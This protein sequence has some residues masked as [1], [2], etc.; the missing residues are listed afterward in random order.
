ML[1]LFVA[2]LQCGMYGAATFVAEDHEQGGSDVR[3]GVLQAAGDLGGEDIAG[4]ADD[5]KL[6]QT[7]VENQF[8]S[9]ARIAATEDGG[10]G[11]LISGEFDELGARESREA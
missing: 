4:D 11:A 6:A 8:R 7:R 3:G 9:D 1:N 5:E 2:R 10:E